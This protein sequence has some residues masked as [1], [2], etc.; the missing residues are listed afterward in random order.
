M[1]CNY[2]LH[3]YTNMPMQQYLY[4]INTYNYFYITYIYIFFHQQK[5]QVTCS[6][7]PAENYSHLFSHNRFVSAIQKTTNHM[8]TVCIL[9]V[10][11]ILSNG[12]Y[13]VMHYVINDYIHVCLR[14][15]I[16]ANQ[17]K[18]LCF[19]NIMNVR[20]TIYNSKYQF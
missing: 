13:M 16:P 11:I 10:V 18:L 17:A 6:L 20:N 4:N 9:C 2:I 8:Y 19:N 3:T 1:S 7:Y 12:L 5:M 15:V 14:E